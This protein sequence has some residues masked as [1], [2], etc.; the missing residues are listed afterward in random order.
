MLVVL[1]VACAAPAARA[2]SPIAAKRAEARRVEAQVNELGLQLEQVVQRWDGQRIAL[3]RVDSRLADANAKLRIAKRNLHAAQ[4]QLLARLRDLYVSP[5]PSAVEIYLRAKSVS[6]LVDQ[7]E[8]AR[9][10]TRQ[11]RDIADAASR[12]RAQLSRQRT[13]LLR[14][15][16]RRMQVIAQ[17]RSE[18]GRIDDG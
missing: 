4:S 13:V 10:L 15:Q 2:A 1:F 11:D 6:Q 5:P 12:F 18:R 3:S 17:L 8:A 14:E 9:V 16:R 7:L